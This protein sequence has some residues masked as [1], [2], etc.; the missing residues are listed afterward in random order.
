MDRLRGTG[1]LVGKGIYSVPDAARLVAIPSA[2]INRWLG[3]RTRIYRGEEIFDRPLWHPELPEVDGQ[4]NLSFRDLIELRL[5]DGF[6]HQGL[7]LPYIRKVV[8]AAQ[9]IVGDTHPFTSYSF[10]TDGR[11]LYHEVLSRTE[12]PKLVEVLNGQHAFHSII[13][14]GLKD[15]E[16]DKGGILAL[17]RP[18]AGREQV[19]LD[20]RRSF[21]QPILA[22][23]GISTAIIQLA[24]AAGRAPRQISHDF[25][26]DE[27]SVRSALA[28]EAKL[29]A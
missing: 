11:R 13:S 25:E 5:V 8:D 18:T 14:D 10:K 21:G 1:S 22:D 27:R 24:S 23:S 15:I 4:V 20:P 2:R 9:V 7:S 19:V 17:W 6:R 26:I 28:F 29:A 3:G 12:E 16:F